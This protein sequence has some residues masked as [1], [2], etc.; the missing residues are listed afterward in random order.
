MVILTE[1]NYHD[2]TNKGLVLLDFYA[3]WC[4]PCQIQL[5]NLNG[6]E[7]TIKE[8]RLTIAKV[9]IE[10]ESAIEERYQVENIPTLILVKDGVEL[11][12]TVGCKTAKQIKKF[13][14]DLLK[15]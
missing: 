3:E 15:R 10:S 8:G 2:V 11:G 13:M 6:L 1:S 12:R 4:H 9:D 5:R 14:G 7:R